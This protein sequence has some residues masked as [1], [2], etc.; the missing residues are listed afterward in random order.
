[1]SAMKKF[2]F[3]FEETELYIPGVT[4]TSM[5]FKTY[6]ANLPPMLRCFHI[7]KISGCSWVSVSK[8]IK[9]EGKNDKIGDNM[10]DKTEDK[11]EGCESY[12]DIE[13]RVDWRDIIPIEKDTNAPLRI[14]SFDIECYSSDR[15]KFP[16]AKNKADCIFQIGSTYTYL[17]ESVPYRQHIVCLKETDDVN[18]S[19]VEWYDNERE[20]VQAWIKEVINNDCDIITGWNIFG[21]D[22]GYIYD[23]CVEHLDLENEILKISKLKNFKCQFRDFKLESAAFGQ[24]KIRMFGTPGR[25][26]IVAWI[27]KP[28]TTTYN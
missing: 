17:N 13:L 19:I 23:R 6:E 15:D 27:N 12:C 4:K 10:E 14:L 3:M 7:K 5:K 21:F 18:G 20:M 16:Q 28:R 8:Y 2:K 22:E 1:M 11:T 9:T 25:I 26:H 24:N